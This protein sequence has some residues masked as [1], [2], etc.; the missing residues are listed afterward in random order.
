MYSG[1]LNKR[2]T[3]LLI[4]E[5]LFLP[6]CSIWSY[7]F[8][9]FWGYWGCNRIENWH[10]PCEQ[11]NMVRIHKKIFPLCLFSPI[12]LLICQRF[13]PLHFYLEHTFIWNTRVVLFIAVPTFSPLLRLSY[14]IWNKL[15]VCKKNVATIQW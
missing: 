10:H 13:S 3:C 5:N 7:T 9:W 14:F 2:T 8:I 15:N 1:V 4:L 12:L 6:I 11:P